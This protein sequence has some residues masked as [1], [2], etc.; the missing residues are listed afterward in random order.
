M[1]GLAGMRK[2]QRL[3]VG[4]CIDLEEIP[5]MET[6]V[7]LEQLVAIECVNLKKIQGLSHYTML[8]FLNVCWSSELE[9]LP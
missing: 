6:L 9:E 5:S 4:C 1:H 7:S 2:I 8:R 3:D